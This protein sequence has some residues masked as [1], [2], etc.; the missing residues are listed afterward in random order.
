MKIAER[1][2]AISGSS[3]VLEGPLAHQL[4][5]L[6]EDHRA[7]VVAGGRRR[8]RH[9]RGLRA[10]GPRLETA[11]V[12]ERLRA[13]GTGPGP[14]VPG[15]RPPKPRRGSSRWYASRVHWVRCCGCRFSVSDERPKKPVPTVIV[16]ARLG[17]SPEPPG[18]P[19]AL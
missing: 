13:G 14:T 10:H 15:P 5:Q 8:H 12:A 3:R 2:S 7:E 18:V 4:P 19:G 17:S 11:E 9:R 1:S 6:V 16:G